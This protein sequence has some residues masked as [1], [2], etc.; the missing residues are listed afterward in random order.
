LKITKIKFIKKR[1]EQNEGV[2]ANVNIV[3]DDLI[4]LNEAKLMLFDE[5]YKLIFPR[6]LSKSNQKRYNY[7]YF[8][9]NEFLLSLTGK[10]VDEWEKLQIDKYQ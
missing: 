5:G 4:V 2:Q 3:L 7:Y 10:V 1:P 8:S 9:D 6:F